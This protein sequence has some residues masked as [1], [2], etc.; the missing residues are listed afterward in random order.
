M[1]SLQLVSSNLNTK[2]ST[3]SQ[4]FL[5]HARVSAMEEILNGGLL[6]QGITKIA[7]CLEKI[8]EASLCQVIL[9]TGQHQRFRAIGA[10]S[11]LYTDFIK[12]CIKDYYA[13]NHLEDDELT[14]K[15]SLLIDG[16]LSQSAAWFGL[17]E[18]AEK[19]DIHASCTLPVVNS[20]GM[21]IALISVFF[22]KKTVPS[23]EKLAVLQQGART[24]AA[25]LTHAKSKTLELRKHVNLHEQLETR[26]IA[27]DESNTLVKKAL[28]Q[29]TEVQS[30]LIELESMAAL[31]TM[32]SSLTHEV[33]TPLGVALTASTYL[34]DMQKV[35]QH[36]LSN[37][38][39]KKSEL[40]DYFHD[41]AEASE[42]IARNLSRADI[43]IKTFKQLSLDQHSQD[44]RSFNICDYVSE[45]L[46]SL[47][48]RLKSRPH[49]FCLDIPTDLKITS[50]AGAISQLL[51]NLILN[52]VQHAFPLGMTGHINIKV[53]LFTTDS[54][55]PKIQLDYTDNG[56]GMSEATIENIYKPFFT[57]ARDSGGTGLGMHICNNIVMKVLRGNIDC[58]SSLGKGVH[59]C[60]QF[61]LQNE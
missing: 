10:T 59:F 58:K 37:D 27:L 30:Q 21:T 1:H 16:D 45:V 46:L 17:L 38:N 5:D 4:R 32:M 36:K 53:R 55:E 3:A 41:A 61:P 57:L 47:K 12:S 11:G 50:N 19:H 23:S 60:I 14:L 26:Q 25:L 52:S 35:V 34:S 6:D 7:L 51:I 48:P 9:H 31:G 39:L 8:T 15:K 22:N 13:Q 2:I 20:V 28:A 49:K 33:N 42:I 44:I 56:I 40:T 24:V 18:S 54:Q 29:R 43:L